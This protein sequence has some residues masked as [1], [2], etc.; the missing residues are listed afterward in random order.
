MSLVLRGADRPESLAVAPTARAAPPGRHR[1]PGHG[2]TEGRLL[3]VLIPAVGGQGG[4]VLAEWL[5]DAGL[6][7]GHAA[8]GTSIP[9]V[10]Q[11][12]GSTT[13]YVEIYAGDRAEPPTFSLYPVAGALDV[14]LAPEFLEVGRAIELGFPSPERTTIV[15][16]THRLFSIHEKMATGRAIHPPGELE[17]AARAFSRTLVAFD[18]LAVAREHGSEVNAV[19]LGALAASDALPIGPEAFREAIERKGIQAEANLRGFDVGLTLGRQRAETPRPSAKRPFRAPPALAE[20]LTVFPDALRPLVGEAD[21][22]RG[23]DS[24][25]RSEDAGQPLRAHPARGAGQG[26]RG[27]G[28]R[29]PQARPRRDLRRAALPARRALRALGRA[30]VAARAAHGRPA[31]EDHDDPRL[32]S[33]VAPGSPPATPSRLVPRPVGARAHGALAYRGSALCRVEQ[34]AR[35]RGRARR[36]ARERLR[37]GPAAHDRRLRRSHP[38]RAAGRITG[39]AAGRTRVGRDRADRGLPAARVAGARAGSQGGRAGRRRHLPAREERAGR[40]TGRHHRVRCRRVNSP[41]RSKSCA[42][43][44]T[45]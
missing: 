37:G 44:F 10:A 30:A 20:S 35:V 25:R 3:S 31:R 17:A 43:R 21:D 6:V 42:V 26:R 19:L 45:K 39:D 40:G 1:P 28:D 16:S 36:P 41:S 7:A 8:H 33:T 23:C 13:Y 34:C 14:L 32:P 12:T 24:R 2:V 22:V 5:V 4:G 15:A 18:A 38:A 9:G 27:R 11:R 29:L